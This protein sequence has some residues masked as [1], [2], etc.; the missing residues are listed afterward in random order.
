GL[1]WI[2]RPASI[3]PGSFVWL[4]QPE[5]AAAMLFSGCSVW[6]AASEAP[7]RRRAGRLLGW[8]V[9]AIAGGVLALQLTRVTPSPASMRAP[10][11]LRVLSLGVALATLGRSGKPSTRICGPAT[12]VAGGLILL[13]RVAYATGAS[14]LYTLT[15]PFRAVPQ[16]FFALC[17]TAL[18]IFFV[19]VA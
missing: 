13:V 14:D 3:D 5:T 4:M 12:A 2:I 9:I 16:T 19:R 10:A 17:A 11:A 18:G 1:A 6:L 7:M 15:P 8:P